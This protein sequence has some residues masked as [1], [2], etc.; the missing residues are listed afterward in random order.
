MPSKLESPTRI[1]TEAI[2]EQDRALKA[3]GL[4]PGKLKKQ[5]KKDW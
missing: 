1:Y 5:I 4:L 3:K 2:K